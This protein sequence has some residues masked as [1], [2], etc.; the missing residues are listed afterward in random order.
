MDDNLENT[1]AV[2]DEIICNQPY[3]VTSD[4]VIVPFRPK[5]DTEGLPTNLYRTRHT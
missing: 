2:T 4:G 1:K 5:E 3:I